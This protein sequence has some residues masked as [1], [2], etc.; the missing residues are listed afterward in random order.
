MDFSVVIPAKNEEANI[1]RCLDSILAVEWDRTRYEIIV[2][3]NGS[4]DRTVEIAVE[5]RA[6]VHV[7]P[8]LTISGLRNYG[9]RAAHG[10]V[11]AFIDA[12]CTVAPSWLREAARYFDRGDIAC[13]G[14][15]PLVPESAT[16]V[17]RG[18]FLVRR[19]KTPV[20]ETEWLESMNMFIRRDV[21]LACK[22]F[23]EELVTCEDY[24]LCLRLRGMGA[25]IICDEKVV[26]VHHG[27]A[28]NLRQF[29]R[30]ER[31]RG[32]SNITGVLRHGVKV[33]E[34][35]SLCLPVLHCL[36]SAALLA[37]PLVALQWSCAAAL[38]CAAAYA[39]WQLM[40]LYFAW[41][42]YSR[43]VVGQAL[44]LSL[45]LNV[46]FLARGLALVR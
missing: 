1:G 19:K 22:G 37:A 5:K 35:P 3:D 41:T 20:G 43:R 36:L 9:V 18:W 13:F 11:V 27:E 7:Q 2:I 14:S 33:S 45:L 17:Q 34:L 21:F 29:F 15:P 28:A 42:R 4:S 10:V 40:L 38:G 39:A 31:W 12:D 26:A 16:W 46:Y 8:G 30:K 32:I 6:T 25:T 24:D 23:D 44:Q